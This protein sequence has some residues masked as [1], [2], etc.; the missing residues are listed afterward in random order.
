[1]NCQEGGDTVSHTVAKTHYDELDILKGIAIVFVVLYHFVGTVVPFGFLGV[2][3]FLV[4]SGFLL[5]KSLLRAMDGDGVRF[6]SFMSKRLLRLLPAVLAAALISF[7]AGFF[8]MLP[9]D[10]E[11]L[12]QSII[13][14][15]VFANNILAAITTKNYWDVVNLFKP[16][17]HTWYLGVLVQTDI[18]IVGITAVIAKYS[19]KPRAVL[20]WVMGALAL[21]SFVLYCLPTFSQA[22]KFYFVPFR[23]YEIAAGA[24]IA[25]FTAGAKPVSRP[26]LAVSVKIVC[27]TLLIAVMAIPTEAI[28]N[29]WKLIASVALSAVFVWFAAVCPSPCVKALL[30]LKSLGQYSYPIYITHQCAVAFFY[31][32]FAAQ[33]TVWGA[34]AFAAAVAVLSVLMVLLVDKPVD[35]LLKKGRA[36]AVWAICLAALVLIGGASGV[37]YLSAGVVRDVPELG[38]VKGESTRGMHGAYCDVPY[39]WDREFSQPDKVKVL[40]VGDSFGRDFANVLNE[41]TIADELEISY[42]YYSFTENEFTD[43]MQQRMQAADCVFISVSSKNDLYEQAKAVVSEEKL[44]M[45]GY[46]NFGNSNGYIY[47][48]RLEPDYFSK[49]Q[50][51]DEEIIRDN[52]QMQQQYGDHFVDLLSVVLREDGRVRVFTD[53]EQFISQDCRHLTQA[54]ARFYAAQ[55]DL[56]WIVNMVA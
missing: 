17:M 41:S 23:F 6:F 1:M 29:Q 19:K 10:F 25:M 30:P 45:V 8:L 36:R 54:G 13:A 27:A 42:M 16:L 33:L 3:I 50:P 49:T 34:V 20:K 26:A 38:I 31:Y 15:S 21:V 48:S 35:A 53:D 44:R 24:L 43:N 28:A 2:E 47:K 52:E 9:D 39:D 5:M 18:V 51:I 7:L 37:V 22:A 56:D 4:I 55:L 14:S 12:S 46:K 32:S 40:V 11:N